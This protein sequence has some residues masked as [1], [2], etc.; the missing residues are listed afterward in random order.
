MRDVMN[1]TLLI[2]CSIL[3]VFES[4]S[5]QKSAKDTWTF[6]VSGDSRNCGDVVM[7]A[8]ARGAIKDEARFY[9]HLGDFRLLSDI[10]DD[11]RHQFHDRLTYAEYKDLAWGDFL[12]NQIA[13]FG[14]TP[15]YLGIGNHE[16]YG[17]KTKA[18]YLGQFSYWLNKP[19]LRAQR[20]SESSDGLMP[21][22][23]YHWKSDHIDFIYLDNSTEE[24]FDDAQLE[25][26]E[27]VLEADKADQVYTLV[28]GMHRALP[29]SLACAHSMNGDVDSQ[30]SAAAKS[31]TGG[32]R[33]YRDLVNWKSSAKNRRVYV[34][35]SHSHFFMQNV[36]D[37][38][39]WKN[40]DHGGTV[41][42]GWIVG[43]AGARRY[44][45]PDLTPEQL[46]ATKAQTKIYG[47]LLGIVHA[48]GEEREIEFKFRE[49]SY[50]DPNYPADE[51]KFKPEFIKECFTDNYQD[52]SR[53]VPDSCKEP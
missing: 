53:P 30:P 27:R 51:G 33:A 5:A 41:L 11:I 15:V 39:Y 49:V 14:T 10:D 20:L 18:D 36:F 48:Q 31:T 24:G 38:A 12:A 47:Y 44:K 19:E 25:W 4:C 45:L 7:P 3:V 8:I 1:R 2:C 35:A 43:T 21:E 32:R 40:V 42:P 13:P 28:V 46:A 34:L 37:T 29:N 50:T 16:L 22:P 17:N 9:W 23:Y 6:A 26:L 52:N